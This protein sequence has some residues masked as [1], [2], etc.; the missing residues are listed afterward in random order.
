MPRKPNAKKPN[1]FVR[2]DCNKSEREEIQRLVCVGEA[3]YK[4]DEESE[5]YCIMHYRS[6]S[7][8]V[9]F[10]ECLQEKLDKKEF[11]FRFV[12]FP[13]LTIEN[14]TFD[15][16]GNFQKAVFNHTTNFRNVVFNKD[17][18]FQDAFFFFYTSFSEVTFNRL[19]IFANCNFDG[20]AFF[21]NL[22]IECKDEKLNPLTSIVIFQFAE[23]KYDFHW[24][25]ICNEIIDF[26]RTTFEQKANF[27]N[28]TFLKGF[29]TFSDATFK[30][31]ASFQNVV[32]GNDSLKEN[33]D[34]FFFTKT[35]FGK[36]V[37]FQNAI[38]LLQTNFSKARFKNFADFRE[39]L[40][41]T[42]INFEDATFESYARFSSK[43]NDHKSW[44]QEGLN[45][46][47]IEVEKPERIFFQTVQLRPD[48]F[49]NTDIRKF[50]FTDIKW[51]V[52]NFAWDWSRFKDI[53]WKRKETKAR[54]TGYVS[55]EKIYRR[56]A[57]FAEENNDYQSASTFRYTAFDIQRITPWYGRLPIT[58]LWWYKWT[59]R[60]GENWVWS[61]IVLA[62]LVFAFF[63][64]IYTNLNFK[65]CSKDRPIYTSISICE[66]KIEEIN[67]N[68]TCSEER[69]NFGDAILQS[70]TTATLQNVEYRKPMTWHGE[71]WIIL[72]KIFAPL[73]AALLA[74]AI[75]RKF[76]R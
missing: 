58:L 56:F 4:D 71:L 10:D 61:A 16:V 64:Y 66:S 35:V 24:N 7:K 50:D 57:S 63:P 28:S 65:T 29:S 26:T 72:E 46:S 5:L 49:K 54:R 34:S 70:L 51:K 45:F 23:F 69:L 31:D 17:A 2:A 30:D 20:Y 18:N 74:L 15:D 27:D 76:M 62:S 33:C 32:F 44:N 41:K 40:V 47:S 43:D 8:K 19:A 9:N 39:T 38:F 73:Q 67:Q 48:S 42:S 75:R 22:T 1:C 13:T 21:S 55:L 53:N 6:S 3:K 11:D 14:F 37:N 25:S 59:S 68:C 36:Q 60:Y 52:K 12:F